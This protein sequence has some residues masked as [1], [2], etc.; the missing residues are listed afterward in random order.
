MV[1]YDSRY[2]LPSD[3][4]TRCAASA[5]HASWSVLASAGAAGRPA[6]VARALAATPEPS[7]LVL[8]GAAAGPPAV[9]RALAATPEPSGTAPAHRIGAAGHDSVDALATEATAP[10]R[11]FAGSRT[12]CDEGHAAAC[13]G[14]REERGVRT[15][16]RGS[17]SPARL[18]AEYCAEIGCEIARGERT[19][20]GRWVAAPAGG[21]KGD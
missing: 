17:L 19:R 8:A 10:S 14:A 21:A 9:A 7:A 12:S 16:N 1:R 15:P 3:A 11:M 4:G 13:V 18:R 5:D 6:A 20:M 2:R